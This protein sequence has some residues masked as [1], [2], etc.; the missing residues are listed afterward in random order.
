MQPCP[1]G[2]KLFDEHDERQ[3]SLSG[4]QTGQIEAK[5]ALR[6]DSGKKRFEIFTRE[7]AF[8]LIVSSLS[9]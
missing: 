5:F 7:M 3:A 4:R 2:G 8:A 9:R 6:F 1:W